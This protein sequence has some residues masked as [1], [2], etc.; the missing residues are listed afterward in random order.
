MKTEIKLRK[1][2]TRSYLPIRKIVC[3][4]QSRAAIPLRVWYSGFF[5][6]Q[7]SPVYQLLDYFRK[8]TVEPSK[9][10]R[11]QRI[12]NHKN[13]ISRENLLSWTV[14]LTS[15]C[16]LW[17]NYFTALGI[18]IFAILFYMYLHVTDFALSYTA[19]NALSALSEFWTI[20]ENIFI[21]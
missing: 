18:K 12:L 13:M 14:V 8:G 7:A 17:K 1:N 21:E 10:W 11:Q 2:Y 4:I 5:I 16:G 15:V 9:P 3:W 20:L 6:I 19:P